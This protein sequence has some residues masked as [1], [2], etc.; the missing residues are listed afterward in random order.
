MVSPELGGLLTV[1]AGVV[2]AA[3][4]GGLVAGIAVAAT[5][6]ALTT[7]GSAAEIYE[8]RETIEKGEARAR[9]A[10]KDVMIRSLLD[11]VIEDAMEKGFNF[12]MFVHSGD[13]R[14]DP[15]RGVYSV[16]GEYVDGRWQ[17]HMNPSYERIAVRPSQRNPGMLDVIIDYRDPTE[18]F[19]R[20]GYDGFEIEDTYGWGQ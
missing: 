18:G 2:I 1:A 12:V 5:G 13:P 14:V 9:E 11:P 15:D 8:S 17:P 6:A 3:T 19:N 20:G 10:C 4:G 7:Y 16:S